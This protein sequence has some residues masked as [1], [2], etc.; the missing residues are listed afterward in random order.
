MST[1]SEMM[2]DFEKRT[3]A[4]ALITHAH[5]RT[6]TATYLGMSRRTLLN[7]IAKYD[8]RTRAGVAAAAE[9]VSSVEQAAT[10]LL[11]HLEEPRRTRVHGALII[12]GIAPFVSSRRP[13][14]V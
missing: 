4:Q 12:H 2:D 9:S 3:L 13:D 5:N 6:H 1:L 10:A 11:T 8:L 14:D 7:K